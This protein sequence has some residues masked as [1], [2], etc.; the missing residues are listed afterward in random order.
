[1]SEH[2]GSASMLHCTI[3]VTARC[4]T[5]CGGDAPTTHRQQ[6]LQILAQTSGFLPRKLN[7]L[8]IV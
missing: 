8:V 5:R 6:L 7:D 3:G 1:M 4:G 2:P